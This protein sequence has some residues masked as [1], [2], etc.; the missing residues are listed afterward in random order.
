MSQVEFG[1][2]HLTSIGAIEST[3]REGRQ[4]L[5]VSIGFDDSLEYARLVDR[6]ELDYIEMTH[7]GSSPIMSRIINR[8]QDQGLKSQVAI[9]VPAREDDLHLA[10]QRNPRVLHVYVPMR[11]PDSTQSVNQSI[12]VGFNALRTALLRTKQKKIDVRVS[13]EHGL[14][15]PIDT[16]GEA[17]RQ[18]TTLDG[19]TRVGLAETTGFYGPEKVVRYAETI[20][21]A[22][23]DDMPLEVHVH[24]DIGLAAAKFYALLNLVAKTG[25]RIDFDVSFSGLGDRNGILSLGDFLAILYM[26]CGP[27]ELRKR[28]HI[29]NY[30]DLY[31]FV[32]KLGLPISSRDPLSRSAFTSSAGPHL[33]AAV[34]GNGK[35]HL[36]HPEDFGAELFLNVGHAVT[37]SQGIRYVVE[38]K[39][40]LQLSTNEYE[41]LAT[42]VR[43]QAA[44][45]G[46]FTDE[47][48]T[49][50]L[51]ENISSQ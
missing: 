42:L 45:N 10:L 5:G 9:H 44:E 2:Q 39:L 17:Y 41:R 16:I 13:L 1:P 6:I 21:E 15:L 47:Q 36:I 43:N 49:N 33:A 23:P 27:E 51:K 19:V 11:E 8:A 24:N 4:G 18:L 14:D 20:F 12:A 32:E 22:T 46:P 28:Y 31:L 38:N 3:L 35:Y 29:K 48:L 50:F 30:W 7:P 37:G 40:D 26:L 25:R 34:N